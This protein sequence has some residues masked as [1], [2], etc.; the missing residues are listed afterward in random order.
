MKNNFFVHPDIS[1]AATLP[2]SFYRNP[3]IF[4]EMKERI[5]SRSWQWIGDE[6]LVEQAQYA[7]PFVLLEHF[8]DEPMLLSRDANDHIHCL[9]NVCT[10]RASL[11]INHPGKVRKLQCPYHG[12]RFGLDGAFE[13]MPEFKK[14]KDFPRPCDNLHSFSLEQW[15]PFL[16]SSLAP[17]YSFSSILEKMNERIGFLDI[18]KW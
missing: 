11:V 4:E 18:G 8:L 17:A 5:F 12:R 15:G 3:Q 16:F 1:Q 7:H 2:A 9:S 6:K 10:H 13:H 14:A